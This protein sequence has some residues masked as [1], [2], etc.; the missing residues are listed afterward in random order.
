VLAELRACSCLASLSLAEPRGLEAL[1]QKTTVWGSVVLPSVGLRVP[2]V[3]VSRSGPGWSLTIPGGTRLTYANGEDFEAALGAP[4]SSAI[5]TRL[6]TSSDS[7]AE[8][9]AAWRE[10]WPAWPKVEVQ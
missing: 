9:E 6:H 7:L 10:R 2:R 3:G 8:E 1:P 5:W 4:L